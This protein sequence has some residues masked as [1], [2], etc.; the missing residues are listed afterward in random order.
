[1]IGRSPSDCLI[2]QAWRR[3]RQKY[4]QTFQPDRTVVIRDTPLDVSAAREAGARAIGV[5][6]GQST[7]EELAAAPAVLPDLTDTDA[8]IRAVYGAS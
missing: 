5:A 2:R 1:M 7:M 4:N 8:V 6:T 3:A